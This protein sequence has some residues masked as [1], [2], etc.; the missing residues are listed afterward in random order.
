MSVTSVCVGNS[1]SF[2]TPVGDFGDGGSATLHRQIELCELFHEPV[3]KWSAWFSPSSRN[4]TYK[5]AT[6]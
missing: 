3:M 1:E 6:A 4:F 5:I 2:S